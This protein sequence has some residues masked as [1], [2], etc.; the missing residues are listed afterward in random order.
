MALSGGVCGMA[1]RCA[2]MPQE[3]HVSLEACLCCIAGRVMHLLP[4]Q[5]LKL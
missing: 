2:L 4:R 3:G 1:Q 5:V